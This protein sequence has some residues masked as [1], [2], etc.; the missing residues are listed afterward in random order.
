MSFLFPAYVWE[1]SSLVAPGCK[2]VERQV[3]YRFVS[4]SVL[5]ISTAPS[6]LHTC[7]HTTPYDTKWICYGRGRLYCSSPLA[8]VP[9]TY[10]RHA[11]IMYTAGARLLASTSLQWPPNF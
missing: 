7:R 1:L 2:N 9:V 3:I 11:L 10:H 8:E 4:R 5:F 6:L